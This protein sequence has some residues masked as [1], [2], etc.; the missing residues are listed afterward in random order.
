MSLVGQTIDRYRILD[1][2]GQGGM[3][4]VYRAHD[5]RLEREVAFKVIRTSEIPES[6][7]Q[8][9]LQR[10]EREAKS[11]A[12]FNHPNIVPVHDYGEHEGQPYLV[13]ALVG[14]GTL[15]ECTGQPMPITE[16]AGL[17]A[18]IA[19]A[20]AYAHS[21]KVLHRDVKPS[22]ILIDE[23][24][25]P[26]LTDFGIA[27]LLEVEEG[28]TLTPTGL[29]IG[30]PE[31][32]APEQ[33]T[34]ESVAQTDIYALG[35]VLY[36]L[37][38]GRK[39]YTA[40]TAASILLKQA[41]ELLT[42]PRQL[43]PNLPEAAEQVILKALALKPEDRYA[44]MAELGAALVGLPVVQTLEDLA[45]TIPEVAATVPDAT[46]VDDR[47]EVDGPTL[48]EIP[49]APLRDIP[50]YEMPAAP[51]RRP[52]PRPA[53]PSPKPPVWGWAVGLIVLA[54]LVM[55]VVGFIVN[56]S[57]G[58]LPALRETPSKAATNYPRLTA[59][60][61]QT[62]TPTATPTRVA[63]SSER[64]AEVAL[65]RTLV[66]HTGAVE[67]IAFAPD[68]ATL[69]SV[70]LDRTVRL[71]YAS[72]GDSLG[73]LEGHIGAV[74]SIVFA[75][76]GATLASAS[77]DGT[78]RLWHASNGA[79]LRILEGHANAVRSVAFAP[80][81]ETLASG[82]SDYTVRLWRASDGALLRIL[83]G[84]TGAVLSV[85][86]APDG[87]MLASA[88]LDGTVRLWRVSDGLLLRTLRGHIGAV[89]S[90]TFSPN[91][92]TLASA[93]LDNSV[94][95]WRVSD[96]ALLRTLQ[97]HT[98]TVWSVSFS[99]DGVILASGGNGTV[100]LWRASDGT[101]LRTLEGHAGAVR[102]VAFSPD[103]ATLASASSDGN[104]RL[105]GIP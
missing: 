62:L 40:N 99:P 27:K 100:Q 35:V 38:T 88:S 76:S 10:F 52:Q 32:M 31:Y 57:G 69:A 98:G 24:G 59:T 77:L 47:F 60:A 1:Q 94:L 84:H 91:G 65:L 96:G 3:A 4:I 101:L 66:G 11:Q 83:E 37:V 95:L 78:V 67:S 58:L 90:V 2:L 26:L 103:G 39:P 16:A 102:S 12:R 61:S 75:S 15:R 48:A 97:Q 7:R 68:G 42:P 51:V 49:A 53:Q 50:R 9:L 63:F 46:V 45:P 19:S 30:T 18:P 23:H 74:E 73:I 6:Q 81:G 92:K 8:R 70:S 55:V 36:E 89:L 5:T 28:Y 64:I 21:R 13:M 20:L 71:W 82:S 22:N 80:D 41:N 34:G 43:V 25:A 93:S 105:W 87:E 86:F 44:S 29:G 104:V 56:R 17:L 79:L 85:A 33:W 72:G 54:L 14:G